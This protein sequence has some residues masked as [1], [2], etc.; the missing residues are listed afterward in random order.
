L[1]CTLPI[2]VLD[3]IV[4][5]TI[6]F[7]TI[8]GTKLLVTVPP[9]MQPHMQL[10]ITGQGMPI[11]GST[12]YGDQILLLKPFVPDNIDTSIIDSIKQAKAKT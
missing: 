10:K 2:S 8:S 3:L 11:N 9:S 4:G 6:E 7:T 5:T 1:Y 12:F